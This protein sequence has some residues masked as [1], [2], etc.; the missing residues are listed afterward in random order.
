[1]VQ[2]GFGQ[3][4]QSPGFWGAILLASVIVWASFYNLANYPTFWWDEAIFSET[5]ANL[6]QHGRYAFTVQSPDQLSDLDHRISAGPAIILPVALAYR[7]FGIGVLQGR[8]VAGLYLIFTFL[9][10]YLASRQLFHRKT[11]FLAVVLAAMGT[12]L[13]GWGRNVMGDVPALGLFLFALWLIIR[14]LAGDSR[15]S[16]FL[17][18]MSLGLAFDAKEFYA[19]AFLPFLGALIWQDRGSLHRLTRHLFA[20]GLGLSIPVLA[21]LILKAVILGGIWPAILHTL[22]QKALLRHEF[23]TPLTVGRLYVQSFGYLFSHPL[24]LWGLVGALWLWSRG[25]LDLGRGLWLSQFFL[26]SLIY[27][28]AIF[29]SRFALPALVLATP[30]AAT[31]LLRV[32][33]GL[34]HGLSPREAKVVTVGLTLGFF[35]WLYPLSGVD[36]MGAIATCKAHPPDRLV[37][38]LL[39]NIPRH[40]LIETPEYELVFLDDM[41]RFHLMPAF[42]LVESSEKGVVLLNPRRS[43][44]DFNEVKAQVLILGS[45]GKTIFGQIYP[46]HKVRKCWRKIAQV[47]YYDIYLRRQPVLPT[48][49]NSAHTGIVSSR[50]QQLNLK[51]SKGHAPNTPHGSIAH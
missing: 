13:F 46:P 3:R 19:V 35:T 1:M 23:F 8:V 39:E 43:P 30:L 12:E 24:F 7:L 4:L 20:L 26:W 14:G 2:K 51:G 50:T 22:E 47:D 27:L 16:L 9:A 38:Y 36:L 44:Y 49:A 11:A 48:P 10:L 17:G 33:S 34:T 18:G 40:Y 41:H 29:W 6:V 42:F 25:G 32:I 5:A 28:T 37:K 15:I 45:F 31:V 21:Y